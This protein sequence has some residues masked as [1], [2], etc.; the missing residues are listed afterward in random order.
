[1]G[2]LLAQVRSA[3]SRERYV[4]GRYA[5]ER[6]RQRC[7]TGWQIVGGVEDAE[8]LVERSDAQPN[9]VVEV[10]QTLADG[11]AVKAVWAYIQ[12]DDV[13]KLVTVHFLDK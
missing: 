4:F 6:L 3:V 13:A 12:S 9:P 1:V 7:I 8:L 2:K 5:N 10:R 11:T